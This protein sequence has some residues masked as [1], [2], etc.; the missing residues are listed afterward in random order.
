MLF[1]LL[2]LSLDFIFDRLFVLLPLV[3]LADVVIVAVELQ[4]TLLFA[5]L[6][7][8]SDS[9]EAIGASDIEV[10][11]FASLF[12]LTGLTPPSES[13]SSM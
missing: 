8:L 9:G 6:T 5:L 2:L 11:L 4:A 1:S 10:G 13:V 7:A 12:L 3:L